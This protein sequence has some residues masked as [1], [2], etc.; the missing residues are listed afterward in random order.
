M[1]AR[2]PCEMSRLEGCLAS[3]DPE[4]FVERHRSRLR[5][6]VYDC[7]CPNYV[8]HMDGNHKLVK[9]GFVIHIAID[10]YY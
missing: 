5:H 4:G 7:P 2:H 10:G 6:R 9:W 3:V 8:W 1:S